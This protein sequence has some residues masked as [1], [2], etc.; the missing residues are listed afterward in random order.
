MLV[1]QEGAK[2]EYPAKKNPRSIRGGTTT[3]H[4]SYNSKQNNKSGFIK[5]VV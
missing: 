2:L 3:T 4:M 5:G 1:I